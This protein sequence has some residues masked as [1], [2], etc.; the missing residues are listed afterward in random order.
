MFKNATKENILYLLF[1]ASLILFDNDINSKVLI[2]IGVIL[3]FNL[4]KENLVHTIK[5]HYPLLLFFGLNIISLLYTSEQKNGI[6]EIEGLL[7]IPAA[8]LIFSS[9]AGK[10]TTL[11]SIGIM[12]ILVVLVATLFSHSQVMLA[13]VENNETSY[14]H[15]FNLNYS[16]KALANTINLHPTYYALYIL[17]AIIFV[18]HFI[19]EKTVS[20]FQKLLLLLIFIYFSLFI[21]Q[22]SSRMAI[23]ILY[24]VTLFNLVQYIIKQKKIIKGLSLLVLFH[25]LAFIL[26]MNIGVTKYRFQHLS[27]FTYYTGYTVNDSNHK[28]KLW[29]AAI[30]AN[31]NI[32]LGNGIGDVQTSLNEQYE[33]AGLKTPL[34]LKY[35]SHNQYIQYYVGLGILG[36]TVFIYLLFYYTKLFI[37]T[38]NSIGLQFILVVAILSFTECLWNRHNGIV[39]I[40]FMIM[41]LEL[42]GR[43]KPIAIT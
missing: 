29:T 31:Q 18:L 9:L 21:V 38:K 28:I 14:K 20:N 42:K 19:K 7:I 34:T 4:T 40:A 23:V 43:N 16:Y 11:R 2:G 41:L 1:F 22:L 37:I 8:L 39:F 12:Y 17:T 25:F 36:L 32:L 30:N 3:L 27:G 15:F 33:K 24:L 6:K 35:N 5:L 13:F 26:I 10:R